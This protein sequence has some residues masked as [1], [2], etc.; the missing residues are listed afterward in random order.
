MEKASGSGEVESLRGGGRI[1][2]GTGCR[3]SQR[4]EGGEQRLM[5]LV[6]D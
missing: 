4:E 3:N 1:V 2:Y 6:E 5:S